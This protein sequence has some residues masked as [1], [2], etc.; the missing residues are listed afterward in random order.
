MRRLQAPISRQ[1]PIVE[2][3]H[4][5]VFAAAAWLFGPTLLLVSR[6]MFAAAM[7]VLFMIDLNERI[8]PNAITL[9]G[10]RRRPGVQ[11]VTPPGFRDALIGS[12]GVQSGALGHGEAVSRSWG[13]TRSASAT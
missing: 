9:P 13:K 5:R 2:L 6:L 4:G 3:D 11:P 10:I 8:L 7:I 1:Y 12:R